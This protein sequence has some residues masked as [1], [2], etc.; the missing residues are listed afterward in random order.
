[1]H[2]FFIAALAVIVGGLAISWVVGRFAPETGA[3]LALT[4]RLVGHI[5]VVVAMAAFTSRAIDRGGW[6]IA[7]APLFILIAASAVLMGSLAAGA[8]WLS[9]SGRVTEE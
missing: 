9:L 7:L 8:L 1:M 3:Q 6:F 5:A 4:A 2:T